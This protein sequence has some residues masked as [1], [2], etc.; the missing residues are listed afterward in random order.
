MLTTF[1]LIV[2]LSFFIHTKIVNANMSKE[3]EKTFITVEIREGDSLSS[4]AYSNMKPGVEISDYINEVKSIN[5]LKSDTIHTGCY[6]L[7]PNYI[8]Q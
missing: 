5:N 7:I 8:E 2:F 3:Y 4:I 1:I 6:L